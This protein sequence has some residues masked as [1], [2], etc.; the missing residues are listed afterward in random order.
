MVSKDGD[1]E[2]LTIDP[3]VLDAHGKPF[4]ME[5][6]HSLEYDIPVPIYVNKDHGFYFA[7]VPFS[8]DAKEFPLGGGKVIASNSVFYGVLP[9]EERDEG[10]ALLN[11]RR[12]DLVDAVVHGVVDSFESLAFSDAHGLAERLDNER[13]IQHY[14]PDGA[15]IVTK[16]PIEEF[17][18][19]KGKYVV[20][21]EFYVHE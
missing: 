7:R 8:C 2:K 4:H 20:T 11:A 1:D 3:Q 13:W 19:L 5:D 18:A 21:L 14:I 6:L 12:K 16:E 9:P 17:W 10:N 15:E